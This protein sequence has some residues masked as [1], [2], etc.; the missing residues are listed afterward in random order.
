MRTGFLAAIVPAIVLLASSASAGDPA[1][2]EVQ[3]DIDKYQL[4]RRLSLDLRS[5]IPTIEEYEALDAEEDVPVEIWISLTWEGDE[6]RRTMRQYHERLFWP[7]I[8]PAKIHDVETLLTD[9]KD[10]YAWRIYSGVRT[11]TMRNHANVGCSDFEQTHF[12]LAHPASS[13]PIR[14]MSRST[15]TASFTRAGATST[16]SG[17][18]YPGRQ[19]QGVRLRRA[20]GRQRPCLRARRSIVRRSPAASSASVAVARACS[21]VIRRASSSTIP[22]R[23]PSASSS[24][25]RGR[26]HRRR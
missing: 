11:K 3:H 9:V 23:H 20:G 17:R 15:P 24:I 1:A 4:L 25:A 21:P 8:I 10:P 12:D 13:A 22:S 6:F 18:S 5:R 7:N 14:P 19:A 16:P 2:C 26:R